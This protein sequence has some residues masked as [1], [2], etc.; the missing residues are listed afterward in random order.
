ME[1]RLSLGSTNLH[2]ETS[3]SLSPTATWKAHHNLM[4]YFIKSLFLGSLWH[5]V[6]SWIF[7][8]L[9]FFL[10]SKSSCLSSPLPDTRHQEQIPSI[11]LKYGRLNIQVMSFVFWA[12]RF[13]FMFIIISPRL[14]HVLFH[15]FASQEIW[16]GKARANKSGRSWDRCKLLP[17]LPPNSRELLGNYWIKWGG[18]LFESLPRAQGNFCLNIIFLSNCFSFIALDASWTKI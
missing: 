16:D 10:A 12:E 8:T 6:P 2:T 13:I 18:I 3:L 7:K 11:L 9:A 15:I 4:L 14:C 5:D 1:K 17:E